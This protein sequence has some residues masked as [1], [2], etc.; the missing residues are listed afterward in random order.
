MNWAEA[1]MGIGIAWAVAFAIWALFKYG[2]G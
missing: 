1:I 2:G